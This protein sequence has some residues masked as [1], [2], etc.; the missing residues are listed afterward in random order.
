M[1]SDDFKQTIKELSNELDAEG[2]EYALIGS[3][4]LALQGM[5]LSPHDLDLVMK[6]DDLRKVPKILSHYLPS[7]VEELRPDS[8]DP[9]W[10]AKL[11]R[12]PAWDVHFI[13]GKIPVQILG[14]PNDG[15]YVS[16]LLANCLVYIELDGAKVPCFSLEAEAE[17]YQE[18]FRP[19]KADK[20]KMFLQTRKTI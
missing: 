4:N 17:V 3:S 20:I 11:E 18:T 14:E 1:L 7:K 6:L 9:A 10:T 16:K 2:L 19:N 8:K 13:M 12:H 15:D 5:D